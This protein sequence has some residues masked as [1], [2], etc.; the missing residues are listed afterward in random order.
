[1]IV[2][3]SWGQL[4]AIIFVGMFYENPPRSQ[5]DWQIVGRNIERFFEFAK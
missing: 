2:I 3:V 5:G 4:Y 1:M